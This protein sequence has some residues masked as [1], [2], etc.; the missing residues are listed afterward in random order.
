MLRHPLL[1]CQFNEE[2]YV[3]AEISGLIQSNDAEAQ[4]QPEESCYVNVL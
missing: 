2:N 4:Y 3:P 1:P